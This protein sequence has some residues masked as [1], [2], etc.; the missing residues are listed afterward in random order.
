MMSDT[1]YASLNRIREEYRR[2]MNAAAD[3]AERKAAAGEMD[4]VSI[5]STESERHRAAFEAMN[6]AI[7]AVETEFAS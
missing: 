5:S 3:I 4:E 7:K 6:R 2:K 1:L